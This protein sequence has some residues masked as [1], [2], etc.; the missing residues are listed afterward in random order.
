MNNK[1]LLLASLLTLAVSGSVN[2]GYGSEDMNTTPE[3]RVDKMYMA[4]SQNVDESLGVN[5]GK[6]FVID[7]VMSSRS[8]ID[9]GGSLTGAAAA[10][11]PTL[12]DLQSK[13]ETKISTLGTYLGTY[14]LTE[15][16]SG[17]APTGTTTISFNGKI[18]YYTTPTNLDADKTKMLIICQV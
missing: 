3:P 16:T 9:R 11:T 7:S 17:T 14:E 10:T 15:L 5:S 2:E 18:Y 6:I 12:D 4:F 8:K 13:T 1:R